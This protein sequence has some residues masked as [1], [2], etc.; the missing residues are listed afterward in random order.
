MAIV[1]LMTWD[2]ALL[3]YSVRG[4]VERET[5]LYKETQIIVAV[6]E[7]ACT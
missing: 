2:L 4:R 5:E 1:E 3:K 6:E 7:S